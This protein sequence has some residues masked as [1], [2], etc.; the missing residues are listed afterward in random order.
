[1]AAAH[2]PGAFGLVV[3]RRSEEAAFYVNALQIHPNVY[4]RSTFTVMRRT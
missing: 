1:V 4:Q 2:G 3:S